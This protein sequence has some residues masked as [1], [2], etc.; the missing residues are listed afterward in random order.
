MPALPTM[1]YFVYLDTCSVLDLLDPN[2]PRHAQAKDL[3]KLFQSYRGTGLLQLRASSWAAAEAHGIVYREE[4]Q[5]VTIPSNSYRGSRIRDT[6]PPRRAQLQAADQ[7]IEPFLQILQTT[8]NFQLLPELGSNSVE[9]W[10]LVAQLAR[11]AA[12]WPADSIHLALALQSGCSML[13]SDDGDLLDKIECCQRTLIQPYRR[14]E[15]SEIRLPLFRAHGIDQRDS[16]IPHRRHSNREPAIQ[17]LYAL[18]F[19]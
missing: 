15:F 6:I 16:I 9:L 2:Q 13:I 17:A 8:T 5:Q 12:L 3:L 4:L 7:R 18:G 11:K 10:D 14:T 19:V 1:P